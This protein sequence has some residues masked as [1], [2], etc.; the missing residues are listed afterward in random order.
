MHSTLNARLHLLLAQ[1]GKRQHKKELVFS[2][3]SG[4]SES[5][6]GMT[7]QEARDMIAYLEGSVTAL[8]PADRMRKKIISMAREMGWEKRVAGKRIADMDRIKAWVM[9]YG[10]FKKPINE[11]EINELP[12]LVT[13]F[14][15]V[16][17]DFLNRL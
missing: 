2:F 5:S 13:Q 17:K 6:R 14:E 16:Y 8:D 4:R 3:T 11:Y 15:K 1:S 12:A 10:Q 7:D 9:K